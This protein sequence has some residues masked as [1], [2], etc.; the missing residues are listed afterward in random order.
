[1]GLDLRLLPFDCNNPNLSFSHTV[2]DCERRRGLFD[3]ILKIEKTVGAAVPRGFASLSNRNPSSGE[4]GY[5]ET[6]RTPYGDTLMA[7]RVCHLLT[8]RKHEGAV[9][10]WKNR[11]IWSYLAE[12]PL[13]TQVALYLH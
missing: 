12:L 6:T 5:G 8:V 10:N 3:V 9:D 4:T 1:M 11:A 2:L 7:I 13:D